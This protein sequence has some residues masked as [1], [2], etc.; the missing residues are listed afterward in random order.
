MLVYESTKSDFLD[1]VLEDQLVP[2]IKRGYESQGIGIGNESEVRSWENSFQYI[3][4]VLSDSAVPADAG[5]AIEFT[6][7]LTSRRVD[8][9]L[10]GYD[11]DDNANV[12][13][14]ELKQWGGERTEPV[15][16]K[17]GI[18]KTFLGGGVRET[19]H[20]SYQARSYA[21]FLRDFNT[22]VQEKPITLS[23]VA[24]LHNFEPRFREKIDNEL[25]QSHTDAAPIYLRG[26]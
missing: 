13:V 16:G 26:D 9:L 20:P 5:V 7:P 6:I 22:T 3:Y 23:P 1:D 4:K 12:V 10:S 19:T 18:V 24:Y 11:G 2:E 15:E 25:Y 14:V 8:F 21:D 17:D